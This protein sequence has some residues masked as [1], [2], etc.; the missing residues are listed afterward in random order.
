MPNEYFKPFNKSTPPDQFF[1]IPARVLGE[2]SKGPMGNGQET[3][4]CLAAVQ[5]IIAHIALVSRPERPRRCK[6]PSPSPGSSLLQAQRHSLEQ[7]TA[8]ARHMD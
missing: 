4:M 1:K 6:D 7:E 3:V 5:R 8:P 2:F